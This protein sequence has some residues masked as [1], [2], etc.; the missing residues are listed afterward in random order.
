MAKHNN[1][2]IITENLLLNLDFKNSKR[3]STNLGTNLVQ[4]PTYNASTWGTFAT[5]KTTGIDAPDGSKNAVRMTSIVRSV[6]YTLTTNVVT[7]TMQAHGFSTG[8]NHYFDFTSG[9][10]VDG[11]YNVT[12]VDANTFTIPVTAANGSGN[13]TVYGRTGMRAT[14][15]SFTPNGTD[16][17]TMS[18]WARLV[19]GTYI[20]SGDA[21][22]CDFNDSAQKNYTS[23]LVVGKWV[24]ITHSVIPTAASKY[25]VDLLSDT[26]TDYVIDFW[27]VKLENQ[28]ADNTY[29]PIKD[30][31]GGYTFNLYRPQYATLT[32]SDITFTRTASTPKWG[33]TL[34]TVGTGSLTSGNFLYNNHTWEIWFKINDITPGGYDGTENSMSNLAC[35]RGSH[36]GFLYSSSVFRYSFWDNTGPTEYSVCSWTL[37]T[38]GTQIIQGNWYQVTITRN[39]NVFT[40]YVN[41]IAT[42]SGSTRS[43]TAYA[44]TSSDILLGGAQGPQIPGGSSYNYYPKNTVANMKMYNRALTASEIL[45]NFNALRGRFG[46]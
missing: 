37:G 38:S 39:G 30:T 22:L 31:I 19:S 42:G 33:G 35:F 6:T 34:K 2:R 18:F 11:Y 24:Y 44:G 32:N 46:I 23:D 12:V 26:F 29:T 45:Q 4:D 40:P 28:T 41:G 5:Y 17:Y 1:P 43:F 36:A 20:K 9:T 8:Q 21:I 10:G 16:T 3:F 25:F 15:T 14:F 7:V 27:G 13:V